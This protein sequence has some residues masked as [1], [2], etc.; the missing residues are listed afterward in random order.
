MTDYL[1]SELLRSNHPQAPGFL[2]GYLDSAGQQLSLS[3]S[4][5]LLDGTMLSEAVLNTTLKTQIAKQG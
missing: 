3:A 1:H 4:G 2:E 5:V